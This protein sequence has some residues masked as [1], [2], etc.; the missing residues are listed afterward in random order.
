MIYFLFATVIKNYVRIIH[1]REKVPK[2]LWLSENY[3]LTLQTVS[4]EDQSGKAF[5]DS[6]LVKV[7]SSHSCSSSSCTS[8]NRKLTALNQESSERT[9]KPR[10]LVVIPKILDLAVLRSE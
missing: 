10:K 6:F 4:M 5:I 7:K 2:A 9:S 3:G 8:S 1:C